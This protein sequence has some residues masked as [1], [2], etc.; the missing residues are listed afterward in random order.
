MSKKNRRDRKPAK[1]VRGNGNGQGTVGQIAPPK[2]TLPSVALP[3]GHH[4]QPA[5]EGFALWV[6]PPGQ[7][8]PQHRIDG[9]VPNAPL[10]LA[11]IEKPGQQPARVQVTLG[12]TPAPEAERAPVSFDSKEVMRRYVNGDHAGAVEAC[13]Q[14]L[15]AFD[16]HS[17][18][19]LTPEVRRL[20]NEFVETLLYL[21]TRPDLVLTRGQTQQLMGGHHTLANLVAMSSFKSTDAHLATLGTQDRNFGKTLLLHTVRNR[22]RIDPKQ[23]FD[24]D[25]HLASMWYATFGIGAVSPISEHVWNNLKGHL[26]YV[27]DR[28]EV[29]DNRINGILFQATYVDDNQ[30]RAIKMR[31]NAD[32]QRQLRDTKTRLAPVRDRIAIISAKWRRGTAVYRSLS[33]LVESLRGKYRL[34][35]VTLG[36]PD[37]DFATEGFD[38]VRSVVLD[39]RSLNCAC[40]KETD[41]QLAFFPDVG[42]SSESIWLSNMRLA[43][44]QAVGYGHPTTTAGTL[45]DYFI[46]GAEV[47]VAEKAQD[48]YTEKLVLIPGLAAV[49]VM[50][51]YA[52]EF[53]PC[54][55]DRI[56]INLPWGVAKINYPI[57]KRL[58]AIQERIT[59]PMEFHFFPGSGIHR[60][61]AIP[62]MRSELGA[63]LG[64]DAK[65][66]SNRSYGEYMR[67]LEDAHFSLDSFPFGGYNTIVDAL[68]LG[69]PVIAQE[70]DRF[71]N[72]ASSALLRRVGL[73]EL[74]AYSE[75]E[76]IDMAVRLANDDDYRADLTQRLRKTDLKTR[77][78]EDDNA[79]YFCKAVDYLIENH[80]RIQR[81]PSRHPIFIR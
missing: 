70:G 19:V 41:F 30:A 11:N 81:A 37:P 47:E 17:I 75:E 61:H 20:V 40:L 28:L 55:D 23:L 64:S 44:I 31:F 1:H 46:G 8:G 33:P 34:T 13:K 54:A 74:I 5:K 9:G 76:Y 59:R 43:P 29:P 4:A 60:Y 7:A 51:N 22:R 39:G 36:Q 58:K 24:A 68:H 18:N 66:Y 21:L 25:P 2:P 35:L 3:V 52:P 79:K 78:F 10:S 63:V 50:P 6:T 45:I 77:I 72:R 73:D 69:K 16:K 53:P 32:I 38:E 56:I 71:Y 12:P 27:D 80:D 42:M 14:A 26:E 48:F 15:E 62:V 57:L 67:E 65:V 49:P